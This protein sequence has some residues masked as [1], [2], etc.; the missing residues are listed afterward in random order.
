[1]GY[2]SQQEQ[3][4]HVHL[5]RQTRCFRLQWLRSPVAVPALVLVR[6]DVGDARTVGLFPTMHMACVR[7]PIYNSRAS[8]YLY[9]IYIF[10]YTVLVFIPSTLQCT[11]RPVPVLVAA[12]K[13]RALALLNG[14]GTGR[15]RGGRREKEGGEGRLSELVHYGIPSLK[16]HRLCHISEYPRAST[17]YEYTETRRRY[18]ALMSQDVTAKSNVHFA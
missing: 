18:V 7:M 2:P 1:M 5:K 10:I 4:Q 6:A 13:W 11:C 9:L 16:F 3:H 8:I 12:I 17:V 14:H 15:E